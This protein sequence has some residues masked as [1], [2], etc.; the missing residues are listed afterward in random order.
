M[1]ALVPDL[2]GVLEPPEPPAG[3]APECAL[4]QSDC[5]VGQEISLITLLAIIHLH[6]SSV[7]NH[8]H[9]RYG[10]YWQLYIIVICM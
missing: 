6:V 2:R 8:I 5:I 9:G 7:L 4:D 10:H 1:F 3:H